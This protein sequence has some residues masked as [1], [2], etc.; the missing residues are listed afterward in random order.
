M[1]IVYSAVIAAAA[2][3]FGISR[4]A[5]IDAA[6][7]VLLVFLAVVSW[8]SFVEI[9]KLFLGKHLVDNSKKPAS[10]FFTDARDIGRVKLPFFIRESVLSAPAEYRKLVF[11]SLTA[12]IFSPLILIS[13][14]LFW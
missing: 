6:K 7:I 10:Y 14:I 9:F 13:T 4:L 2:L 11:S 5:E 3:T 1:I 12:L 8:F